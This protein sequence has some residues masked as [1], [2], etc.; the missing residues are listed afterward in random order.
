MEWVETT[1]RTTD[2]AREAALDQ[3]GV[4]EDDAEFEVVTPGKTGLFGRIKEEARV[5]ARVRPATPRAKEQGQRRRRKPTEKRSGGQG[6]SGGRQRNAKSEQSS[7]EKPVD[8]AEGGTK[9]EE[10][11]RGDSEGAPRKRNKSRREKKPVS[12][13]IEGV[14]MGED[15]VPLDQQGEVAEEFLR[16]FFDSLDLDNEV[17]YERRVN[18]DDAIV[19]VLVNGDGLGHLI[20]PRGSTLHSLQ[21]ITRTV[22]QR[23]TESR[24]ARIVLDIS[25]YRE[26]RQEALAEFTRKVAQEVISEGA[27]RSLEPMNPADRKVVH[28]AVNDIDGV[29]T[30]SEGEEPRRR[31][32]IS[33]AGD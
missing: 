13:G 3:L 32:V 11:K 33:P 15:E 6:S 2:E 31:V 19:K 25:G 1:G 23:K 22:V 5:R 21:E 28:D 16:G 30:S 12:S 20:G 27:S 29:V 7:A 14:P 17:T 10:P 26:K 8:P 9:R 24:T 4:A 18:E